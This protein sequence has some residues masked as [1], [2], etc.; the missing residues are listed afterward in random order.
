[1]RVQIQKT[2]AL[3]RDKSSVIDTRAL[4]YM[5][6][7]RQDDPPSSSLAA[8]SLVSNKIR[9]EIKRKGFCPCWSAEIREGRRANDFFNSAEC[10][11][12]K[13]K[14]KKNGCTS[15]PAA[16]MIF[17]PHKNYPAGAFLHHMLVFPPLKPYKKGS[18][19]GGIVTLPEQRSNSAWRRQ[20][21]L[22]R[23]ERRLNEV[24]SSRFLDIAL[25]SRSSATIGR[26]SALEQ[27]T[28][29]KKEQNYSHNVYNDE[30]DE[31][32]KLTLHRCNATRFSWQMYASWEAS[33]YK[34]R[35]IIQTGVKQ[36]LWKRKWKF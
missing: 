17:S 30:G 3:R 18:N 23:I 1:M 29:Q 7:R 9:V 20:G 34:N 15:Q 24:K 33:E 27:S 10:I 31:H 28:I 16:Q 35:R 32:L 5:V 8:R 2:G 19:P 36:V 12:K 6:D 13:K 22:G 14:K 26:S 4:F 11:K 25:K 21:A